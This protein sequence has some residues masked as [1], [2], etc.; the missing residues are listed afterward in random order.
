MPAKVLTSLQPRDKLRA[1]LLGHH[2]PGSFKCVLVP[3]CGA[4]CHLALPHGENREAGVNPARSRHCE[5]HRQSEAMTKP[6]DLPERCR[7]FER[8]RKGVQ[9]AVGIFS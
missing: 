1:Q 7:S 2:V 6:G 5:V 9:A 3:R 8:P 4:R